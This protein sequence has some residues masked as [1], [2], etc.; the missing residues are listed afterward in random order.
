[1]RSIV[2]RWTSSTRDAEALRPA[3]VEL[4]D[5]VGVEAAR[6]EAVDPDRDDLL[7]QRLD[8]AGQPGSQ[9][10][11]GR[12]AGDRLADRARQDDQDGRVAAVAEVRQGGPE[13]AHGAPQRAVDGGL[14][15]RLVDVLEAP[16]R[17]AAGVDDQQVQ[18]AE[19]LDRG[20]HRRG[21]A[22]RRREVGRDR[23]R[24]EPG[25]RGIEPIAR[26]RRQPDGG[27][28]GPEHLGD[29]AA[30]AA[31]AATDERATVAQSEIHDRLSWRACRV[32]TGSR[33]RTTGRRTRGPSPRPRRY[34]VRRASVRACPPA[35]PPRCTRGPGS[36][37]SCPGWRGAAA[38][39]VG[40]P[41]VVEPPGLEPGIGRWT[42]VAVRRRAVADPGDPVGDDRDERDALVARP[43]G[44]LER[45]HLQP[46]P[47]RIADVRPGDGRRRWTRPRR[48]T[49][50]RRRG[51]AGRARRPAS[52]PR[53]RTRRAAG[54][55]TDWAT[56]RRSPRRSVAAAIAGVGAGKNRSQ[57][58]TTAAPR[59]MPTRNVA[60]G[61]TRLTR[62]R[63]DRLDPELA[64]VI[65]HR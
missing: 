12:Q 63:A 32:G 50:H 30:E 53:T 42:V 64:A 54:S 14:P 60:I 41:A 26:T 52:R 34:S 37:T 25:R 13:E 9:Q 5:A 15:G 57:G 49:R 44:G 58:L 6:R 40:V 61:T 17:R 55:V 4:G 20:G 28:L 7:D 45:I 51:P 59:K 38:E 62:L 29:G 18:A 22:V 65:V 8:Q 3:R 19:R 11:R 10:V 31:A 36:W 2:R 21:R 43:G 56:G 27:A 35:D 16:G 48:S 1:M 47:E 46:A 23:Q 24:A 39:A 33:P